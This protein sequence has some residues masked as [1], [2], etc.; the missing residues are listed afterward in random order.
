MTPRELRTIG[1]SLFGKE[2][3]TALAKALPMSPRSVR[4][5]KSGKTKIREVIANRIRDLEKQ[6]NATES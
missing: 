4:D 2:W 5:W 3:Q 1:Q 6:L